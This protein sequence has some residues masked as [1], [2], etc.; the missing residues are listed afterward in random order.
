MELTFKIPGDKGLVF[1]QLRR[2]KEV[3][4]IFANLC[5]PPDLAGITRGIT[6]RVPWPPYDHVKIERTAGGG[7]NTPRANI[8]EGI[9]GKGLPERYVIEKRP[10]DS[11][12]LTEDELKDI[13]VRLIAY[14]FRGHITIFFCE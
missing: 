5:A 13:L 1:L 3:S 9:A 11:R 2:S 12:F 4:R 14:G 8:L 6:C 10:L 7:K